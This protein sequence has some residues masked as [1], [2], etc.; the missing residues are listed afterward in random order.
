IPSHKF[1]SNFLEYYEEYVKLNKRKGNRHLTN[2]L[3][4]FKLFVNSD[5]IS[6]IEITENFCKRF[7]QYLL[8]KY[9]GET[10]GGYYARFKWVVNAATSDGYFQKNPTENVAAKSNPSLALKENLEVDEYL[11]LLNT[12]CLNEEIKA[13]FIFS[14][15]TGLR[16][17]DVKKPEWK[18]IKDGVLTTRIIQAKTGKPV[19]LTLHPIAESILE[20]QKRKTGNDTH[21]FHLP[22]ADGANKVLNGWMNAAGIHKHI[23]WSCARL[24]FS[25][26]LQDR[27]VDDATVAY[28][29]G[30]TTTEQVR[31]TYKRHRP[32][33]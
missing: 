24:S 31:K 2:S 33:N 25:I 3:K 4:Q 29:M 30:H 5:F 21:V 17:V 15:Y 22:T 26:L 10:P 16:W 32:K 7:R 20:K 19:T 11:L 1:K 18:D 28:L 9:T 13:A 12:P 27:N 8:D 23:T 14:C 6:P